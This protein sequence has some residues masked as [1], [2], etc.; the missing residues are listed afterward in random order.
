[1]NQIVRFAK[2]VDQFGVS[3]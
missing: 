2:L 1:M 3:F